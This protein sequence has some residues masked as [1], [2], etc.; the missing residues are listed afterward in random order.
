MGYDFTPT[1]NIFNQLSNAGQRLFGAPT[2]V[3]L[4]DDNAIFLGSNAMRNR[5]NLLLGL[6]QNWWN[7]GMPDPNATLAAWGRRP[8]NGTENVAEWF[9]LFGAPNDDKLVETAVMAA[10][11]LPFATPNAGD[12]KH[13]STA[14]ALAAMSPNF[15]LC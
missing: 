2:P 15:Q 14:S 9:G 3:G 4:P 7:T 6:A 12:D 10:G 11:L 5:W 1:E 13:V 8:G